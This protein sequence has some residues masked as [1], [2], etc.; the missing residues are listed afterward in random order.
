MPL[1]N[2]H[3]Q[4]MRLAQQKK[5]GDSASLSKTKARPKA[6]SF[7]STVSTMAPLSPAISEECIAS[8]SPTNG[9]ECMASKYEELQDKFEQLQLVHEEKCNELGE[10]KDELV[11]CK[12]DLKAAMIAIHELQLLLKSQTGA[13]RTSIVPDKI[14]AGISAVG[15]KNQ[16]D[17]LCRMFSW[18]AE[19]VD[20]D[21]RRQFDASEHNLVLA[22]QQV[23]MG[24][25]VQ[26]RLKDSDLRLTVPEE[27]ASEVSELLAAAKVNPSILSD[28]SK[29]GIQ[30]SWLRT[31]AV[32]EIDGVSGATLLT[33]RLSHVHCIVANFPEPHPVQEFGGFK[34]DEIVE[35]NSN[36][37][38]EWKW[39]IGVVKSI[40]ADGE[41]LVQCDVDPLGL[42]TICTVDLLRRPVPRAEPTSEVGK[43]PEVT[44]SP[45]P[46]PQLITAEVARSLPE[47]LS[48]HQQK[49]TFSHTRTRTCPWM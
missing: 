39:Y 11:E 27:L 49:K 10:C 43:I 6:R 44:K 33:H 12:N 41:F 28:A 23:Q 32:S 40:H 16:E 1:G 47:P 5:N 36:C 42:L 48:S 17:E 15:R 31:D 34:V 18:L 20:L 35:V 30:E 22:G 25:I 8:K 45:Q 46:Q 21:D 13:Q 37:D 2:A 24:N 7:D 4:L 14:V 19:Q 3:L 29:K 26:W 38:G 9:E